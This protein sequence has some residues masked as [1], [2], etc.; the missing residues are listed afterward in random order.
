MPNNQKCYQLSLA[1]S[2]SKVSRM[3]IGSCRCLSSWSCLWHSIFPTSSCF[4]ILFK[5]PMT[6][7]H[8]LYDQYSPLLIFVALLT[9][10]VRAS[11]GDVLVRF[12]AG[13]SWPPKRML[14]T[15]CLMWH[16]LSVDTVTES[17]ELMSWRHLLEKVCELSQLGI[18][19]STDLTYTSHWLA[20]ISYIFRTGWQGA[21]NVLA[22][23]NFGKPLGI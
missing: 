19:N 20:G 17:Q 14:W 16:V 12:S 9:H 2:S 11:V 7:C 10:K 6:V 22:T 13:L 21:K 8:R 1:I 5:K 4:V 18:L 15:S 23:L 3:C